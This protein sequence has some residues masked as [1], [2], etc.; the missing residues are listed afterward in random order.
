MRTKRAIALVTAL[1][2]G[3]PACTPYDA[4]RP[5]EVRTGPVPTPAAYGAQP[6]VPTVHAPDKWWTAFGDRD[7]DALME[8]V[9]HDN[10]DLRQAWAR[11]EQA[12]A[13]A[14][15]ASAARLP[16]GVGRASTQYGRTVQ[17]TAPARSGQTLGET[18]A[19]SSQNEVSL[20]ASYE[21]DV[22]GKAKSQARGARYDVT[23]SRLDVEA[24]AMTLAASVAE[25]WFSLVEAR[26]ERALLDEQVRTGETLVKVA[27]GRFG[28]GQA[29]AVDVYQA[30]EQLLVTKAELPAAQARVEL[31]EH[32]LAALAGQVPAEGKG[33]SGGRAR[34]PDLPPPPQTGV[35]S[36][37]LRARPDVESAQQRVAAADQRVAVAVADRFPSFRI[38]LTTGFQASSFAGLIDR[39]VFSILANMA[40]PLFDGGRR[41]AEV[42]KQ[43]AIVEERLAALGAAFLNALKEVEDAVVSET[44][45]R[46][47]VL[48]VVAQADMADK[49]LAETRVRYGAGLSDYL[50]VLD[51]TRQQQGA[52]IAL[53]QARLALVVQRIRLYRA[54]GGAWTRDLA[55]PAHVPRREATPESKERR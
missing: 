11:L 44:H 47:R 38:S 2:A 9:E 29:S 50:P 45:A 16:V 48:A 7:L 34:L 1:A 13:A 41:K 51:A 19:P 17:P 35:P 40:A 23:A 6:A 30:R 27:E 18:V 54:L 32:E 46:E 8:R 28:Q 26:A 42:K 24:L 4:L 15:V 12:Q 3:A 53:T 20:A 25:T 33:L 37:L 21:I 10:L 31:L 36:D 39:F 52:Q 14:G 55:A 5:G 22:W 43:K 49:L